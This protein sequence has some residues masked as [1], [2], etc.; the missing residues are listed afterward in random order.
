[1]NN[2]RNTIA[3]GLVVLVLIINIL[4][5]FLPDYLP[6]PIQSFLDS[7]LIPIF[8]VLL[9]LL[10]AVWAV[11]GILHLYTTYIAQRFDASYYAKTFIAQYDRESQ[12]P[13]NP[14]VEPIFRDDLKQK[15]IPLMY[16]ADDGESGSLDAFI[17]QW[18]AAQRPQSLVILGDYGS[19][20]TTFCLTLMY[21]CLVAYQQEP[22]KN[23]LPLYFSFRDIFTLKAND[24]PE[25]QMINI[26]T[27]QYGIQLGR[28]ESG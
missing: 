12:N 11:N 8:I 6:A 1:M 15:F 28:C 9:I 16:V 10:C 24:T 21:R 2:K 27:E 3:G 18:L 26:L 5:G 7:W 22:K 19:G 25:Q 14:I 20:K 17:D 4:L 23:I 13:T